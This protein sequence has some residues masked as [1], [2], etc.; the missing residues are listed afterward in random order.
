MSISAL[1]EKYKLKRFNLVE[2]T[3]LSLTLFS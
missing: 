2:L 3:W 1:R